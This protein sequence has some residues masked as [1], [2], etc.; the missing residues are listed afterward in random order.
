[1]G[2]SI[3]WIKR[4]LAVWLILLL[5]APCSIAAVGPQSAAQSSTQA[6]KAAAANSATPT[7]GS[8][9]A[10]ITY[11]D[12]PLPM[13]VKPVQQTS[14][15]QSAPQTQP[16][17]QPQT[18][19]P[20]NQQTTQ[21]VGTAAAPYIKPAGMPASNPAGAAIAP[22]KQRR[23]RVFAIRIALLVGAGIAIGTVAALSMGSPSRAN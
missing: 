14:G 22:A 2:N 7:A 16:Q 6:Q 19:A 21:P 1:M 11:P 4:Q 17:A 10:A 13:L 23:T 18:S 12:A 20:A 15:Q 9:Q 5:T 3:Q 8:T